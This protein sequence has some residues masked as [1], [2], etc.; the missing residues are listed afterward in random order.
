MRG[1]PTGRE[2]ESSRKEGR[3]RRG[4][5]SRLPPVLLLAMQKPPSANRLHA[6][7]EPL[8]SEGAIVL[9]W[10]GLERKEGHDGGV[11]QRRGD[12]PGPSTS[13]VRLWLFTVP[14]HA[15]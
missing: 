3:R 4:G 15:Q 5:Q 9:D 10:K 7:P 14:Q 13:P 12:P 6:N 11:Q 2:G 1:R 8:G